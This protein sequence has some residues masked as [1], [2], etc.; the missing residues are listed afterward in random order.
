MP[1][2]IKAESILQESLELDGGRGF[3]L[4]EK[5]ANTRTF[6]FAVYDVVKRVLDLIIAAVMLVVLSPVLLIV[7]LVVKLDSPGPVLFRQERTGKNGK[8]FEILKFRSM[9]VDNDVRDN[10]CGDKYTRVGGVLR[11]TSLDELPQLLNIL[12]G[13]MSF[14]GPRPWIPEYWNN[15]SAA[16][17]ER[18]KVRPGI[19][20]LAAAKGRND[21]TVFQKI[22]YDLEYVRNYSLKQDIKVV[23][24]TVK[25]V[26]GKEG[27][28]AGKGGIHDEIEDLKQEDKGPK[29]RIIVKTDPLVSVV[30]P[31]G[32]GE[33]YIREIVS[34][35]M[36][37]TCKRMELVVANSDYTDEARQIMKKFS[38]DKIKVVRG[39]NDRDEREMMSD[40][41]EGRFLC[42][43][44]AKEVWRPG[45][46]VELTEKSSKA[47][48][49]DL[50]AVA[51]GEA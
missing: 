10:S 41:I 44:E 25:T 16:G 31:L 7:A 30:V 9:A 49:E 51:S 28:E 27:A 26:L 20:G 4:G 39:R 48:S 46:L 50:A 6:R 8:T 33:E 18:S 13:Q 23:L 35:A 22:A 12:M 1:R 42:Y 37:R 36:G 2:D 43:V 17:R 14:I 40:G 29:A 3:W 38:P 24:M 45:R 11:R 47:R 15:M 21:L 32:N 34:S 19:T 5:R